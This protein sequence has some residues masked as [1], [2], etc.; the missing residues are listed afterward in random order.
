MMQSITTSAPPT[1]IEPVDDQIQLNNLMMAQVNTALAPIFELLNRAPTVQMCA[2]V[3]LVLISFGMELYRALAVAEAERQPQEQLSE[4]TLKTSSGFANAYGSPIVSGLTNKLDLR[5]AFN[6]RPPPM[7]PFGDE[8]MP[9]LGEVTRDLQLIGDD[10]RQRG[11][12]IVASMPDLIEADLEHAPGSMLTASFSVTARR[13]HPFA[14]K[15]FHLFHGDDG[16]KTQ[17]ILVPSHS[18]TRRH[19]LSILDAFLA[20]RQLHPTRGSTDDELHA[21]VDAELR[22]SL[23]AISAVL[24]SAPPEVLDAPLDWTTMTPRGRAQHVIARCC[25]LFSETLSPRTEPIRRERAPDGPATGLGL[26]PITGAA[27]GATILGEHEPNGP[28]SYAASGEFLPHWRNG[29]FLDL[30][31]VIDRLRDRG[32]KIDDYDPSTLLNRDTPVTARFAP[33]ICA[34]IR[35]SQTERQPYV[36]NIA[37]EIAPNTEPETLLSSHSTTGADLLWTIA[38]FLAGLRA[39]PQTAPAPL[40]KIQKLVRDQVAQAIDADCH[41]AGPIKL[42]CLQKTDVNSEL[43][44]I[45]RELPL[46]ATSLRSF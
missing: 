43:A 22:E 30:A 14:F 6:G 25:T 32:F 38:V 34:T 36:L 37:K 24:D 35:V 11:F 41:N 33:D 31:E 28:A 16:R 26:P 29:A 17:S 9:R 15:M 40:T 20:G 44:E 2:D 5:P 7:P 27:Y 46:L 39:H 10:L 3:T 12:A 13:T 23:R 42:A 8:P 4:D 21:L 18:G 19:L 45:S 1:H